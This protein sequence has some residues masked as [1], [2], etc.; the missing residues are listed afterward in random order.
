MSH[1]Y[2]D[3]YRQETARSEPEVERYDLEEEKDMD[4]YIEDRR[5]EFYEE[6]EEYLAQEE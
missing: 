4:Q 5:W 3:I 6:W 1:R 2:R